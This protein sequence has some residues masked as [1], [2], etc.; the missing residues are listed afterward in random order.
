MRNTADNI[1]IAISIHIMEVIA[2]L[3]CIDV[4]FFYNPTMLYRLRNTSS[5]FIHDTGKDFVRFSIEHANK[6]NPFFFSITETNNVSL[7][8]LW[9]LLGLEHWNIF[10]FSRNQHTAS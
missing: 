10:L 5:L 6:S 1:W 7:K 4:F 3:S 2:A 9:T 8:R